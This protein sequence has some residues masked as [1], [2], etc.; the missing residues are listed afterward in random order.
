MLATGWRR[1]E[2]RM[3]PLGQSNAATRSVASFSFFTLPAPA[4]MDSG[5]SIRTPS[6]YT[7]ENTE[8]V[9]LNRPENKR[10][11]PAE[12]AERLWDEIPDGQRVFDVLEALAMLTHVGLKDALDKVSEGASKELLQQILDTFRPTAQLI[13]AIN[14]AFSDEGGDE[15]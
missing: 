2:N 5:I 11:K 14:S 12:I 8:M 15:A 13:V 10:Q 6:V 7:L 9:A 3:P 1:L 4:Q